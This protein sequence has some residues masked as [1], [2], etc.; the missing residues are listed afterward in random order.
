ME[1]LTSIYD[2][3]PMLIYDLIDKGVDVNL[4]AYRRIT[5]LM[6]VVKRSDDAKLVKALIATGANVHARNLFGRTPLM[7]SAKNKDAPEV[8]KVL[9]EA[10]SDANAVDDY[11]NT[12]I[13]YAEMYCRCGK[14]RIQLEVASKNNCI[15]FNSI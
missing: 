5:F 10:G 2:R 1:K 14:C 11:G 3:D 6:Y 15:N 8:I 7:I 4:I 9:L 13:K 12:A